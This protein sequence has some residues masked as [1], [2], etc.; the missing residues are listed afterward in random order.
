[1]ALPDDDNTTRIDEV[2]PSDQQSFTF[3]DLPGNAWR[4]STYDI[5]MRA[6]C[7]AGT[8]VIRTAVTGG[9]GYGAF[10]DNTTTISYQDFTDTDLQEA[11]PA[12]MLTP[13][14][15][16]AMEVRLI[17][18]A[19]GGN[20]VRV[21]TLYASVTWFAQDGGSSFLLSEWALPLIG[22]G[23]MTYQ[24]ISTMLRSFKTRPSHPLEFDAI[25]EELRKAKNGYCF[26]G[27]HALQA[28]L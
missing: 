9:A 8:I 21:T 18:I 23:T 12:T 19:G 11:G 17:K 20:A 27:Q 14:K 6:A 10:S 4:V 25:R 13:A 22:L 28:A 1:V 16:N 15:I 2:T 5:V 7:T 24:E 26:I 3:E